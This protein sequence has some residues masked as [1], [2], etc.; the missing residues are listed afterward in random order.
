MVFSMKQLVSIIMQF[1]NEKN[2]KFF[3]AFNQS[4]Y[5]KKKQ[6]TSQ[7]KICRPFEIYKNHNTNCKNCI[8]FGCIQIIF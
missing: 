8:W 2:V 3:V 7:N 6:S 4:T 1:S 5:L